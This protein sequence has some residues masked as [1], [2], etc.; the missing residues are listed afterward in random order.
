MARAKVQKNTML[1]IRRE[2]T[3]PAAVQQWRL[4][5]VQES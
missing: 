2:E 1:S 3:N 4:K 5:V